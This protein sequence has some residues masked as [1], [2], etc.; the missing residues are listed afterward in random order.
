MPGM[1]HQVTANNPLVVSAFHATLLHQLLLLLAIGVALALAWN[2]AFTLHQRRTARADGSAEGSRQGAALGAGPGAAALVT[3]EPPGRRVLRIAFGLLWVVDG[4]LQVQSAMPLGMPTNVVR[5]A[6][7]GSPSWVHDVVNAGLT[8]WTNH[9]VQAAASVVWIQL[10]IGLAL[11][12]APRGWWSRAAGAASVGWGLVVWV[13]GEAFGGIFAPGQQWAFGLPG[14]VVFYVV[15]GLLVAL[16]ERS[17]RGTRLGRL[18]VGAI[19]LFFVGMAVLQAWPSNGNWHGSFSAPLATMAR[20]MSTTPQPHVLASWLTSFAS[21]DAAHGWG[22]NLFLVV[23]LGCIGVVLCAGRGRLL[24]AGSLAAGVLCLATWVLVQD[25]GVLGGVG[26]DPNSM[27][28]TVLLLAGGTVAVLRAPAASTE[29][30]LLSWREVVARHG[31]ETGGR[32]PLEVLSP[33]V[34]ARMAG[35]V[36]AAAVVLVGI[37]PMASASLNSTATVIVTEAENG[38]PNALNAPAR[39]FDL[40]DQAGKQVTLASLKGKAV[41]LTF[42]DPVCTSDCPMIAQSF[43]V[44]DEMLGSAAKDTEF[45]AIVTNPL[46][47][48]LAATRAF[49]R[50]EGM[51]RVSNWLYLTGSVTALKKVWDAYGVQVTV[52]P[53]G[54]MVGHAELAYIIDRDGRLREVL[55]SEPG[56]TASSRD[57]MSVL[58]AN[59]MRAVL[60]K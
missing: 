47:H 45:V 16:P 52:T 19:G 39:P 49:D 44:A 54:S 34:L 15:A 41:A 56:S 3:P 55:D 40:V 14:G 27:L 48:S 37:V 51:T 26:T 32:R 2:V 31:N 18:V 35:G 22:V 25:F 60:A 43:R 9:P 46:Y 28:P 42:L 36:L 59:E 57:S 4:L 5:P 12:L 21:F 24:L 13:F 53:A 23:A 29:P 33:G 50:Q 1:S 6:A 58:V 17:W 11:L 8:I 7:A 10:G 30:V 20:T 38:T